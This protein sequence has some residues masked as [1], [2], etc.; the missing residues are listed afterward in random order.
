[1]KKVW[2]IGA[3]D[4]ARQMG[5]A[6]SEGCVDAARVAVQK[7]IFGRE[8]M[9]CA[10]LHYPASCCAERFEDKALEFPEA[11]AYS[12]ASPPFLPRR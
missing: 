2:L 5:S 12:Q 8:D 7:G 10:P 1:M 6:V 3:R 9:A 11:W 4:S